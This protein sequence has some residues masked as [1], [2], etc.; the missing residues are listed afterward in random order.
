MSV[1]VSTDVQ[2]DSPLNS[3][4]VGVVIRIDKL[5]SDKRGIAIHV[6]SPSSTAANW[7]QANV[8]GLKPHLPEISTFREDLSGLGPEM[9]GGLD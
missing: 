4:F 5:E 3:T 9:D 1:Y 6:V 8:I 2:P 7:F